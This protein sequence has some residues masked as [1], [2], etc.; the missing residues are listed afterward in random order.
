MFRNQEVAIKSLKP[1]GFRKDMADETE[2]KKFLDEGRLLQNINHKNIV[3][4]IGIVYDSNPIK[5][6]MEYIN[7]GSLLNYIKTHFDIKI[8]MMLRFCED[9]ARGMEFLEQKNVIHR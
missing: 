6:V 8:S 2:K 3:R 9:C 1:D 4:F 7:G 5:I